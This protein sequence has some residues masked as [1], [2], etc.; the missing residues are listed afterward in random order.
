MMGVGEDLKGRRG[1]PRLRKWAGFAR[2]AGLLG[3]ALLATLLHSRALAAVAVIAVV[4]LTALLLPWLTVRGVTVRWSYPLRRGQVGKPLAVRLRLR[5]ALPWPAVGLVLRGGWSAVADPASDPV[6]VALPHLSARGKREVAA[7]VTPTQ[8]GIYPQHPATV[9]TS[10]PFGLYHATGRAESSGQ[11]LVWPE[12]VPLSASA[13]AAGGAGHGLA[14]RARRSGS[15]GEFFG[16]RPYR[17]GEPLRQIHWK[18]SARHDQL[19]IWESRA[20]T[21]GA[22]VLLLETAPAVHTRHAGG[23]SLEKALSVVASFAAAL[24]EEGLHVTLAFEPGPALCAATRHEL[25]P[26][27]DALAC[28]DASRGAGLEALLAGLP[29]GLARSAEV[30][31]LTTVAGWR[32]GGRPRRACKLV[33]IDERPSDVRASGAA[34]AALPANV[35]CVPLVDPDHRR[36]LEAWKEVAA[37]GEAL[38]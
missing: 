2:V 20:A 1:R 38:V 24:V 23:D 22:V 21:R 26:A 34:E 36:L 35:A 37:Y 31:A 17:V 14:A 13:R 3:V 19:I 30:W 32:R 5:S 4:L 15:H 25:I 10:F 11:V 16:A 9:A 12:I 6:T 18:Q 29:P 27:L 28:F 33:L 8:R 7:T